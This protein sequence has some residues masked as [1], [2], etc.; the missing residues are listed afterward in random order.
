MSLE[1]QPTTSYWVPVVNSNGQELCQLSLRAKTRWILSAKSRIFAGGWWALL[2]CPKHYKGL[3]LTPA[4][5]QISVIG[6]LLRQTKSCHRAQNPKPLTCI[7]GIG[8]HREATM[9]EKIVLYNTEGRD[10]TT[11]RHVHRSLSRDHC[12]QTAFNMTRWPVLQV[13][14]SCT[15]SLQANLII[16]SFSFLKTSC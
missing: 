8:G 6:V 11:D 14:T 3:I 12:Q 5:F 4:G 1:A 2:L 15:T 10:V 13:S 16:C 7:S 9:L